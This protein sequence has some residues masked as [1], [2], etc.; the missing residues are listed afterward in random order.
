PA[1]YLGRYFKSSLLTVL[2]VSEVELGQLYSLYGAVAM[3]CYLLGGPIA[4]RVAPRKLIAGSLLATAAGGLWLASVPG[5]NALR[6]L[7]AFWGASTILAFWAPL[8]RATRELG[9]DDAQGRAFGLLDGG[10]G[11]AAALVAVA[12][13][14]GVAVL[15]G[16]DALDNATSELAAVR[17]LALFYAGCCVT[18]AVAVW[19]CLPDFATTSDAHPL[20]DTDMPNADMADGK[21]PDAAWRRVLA[22]ARLPAIWL[23]ALVVISAYTAFKAIDYYGLFCED[24]YGL[25]EAESARVVTWLSFL[26]VGAALAAGWIADRWLRASGTILSGFLML[27]VGYGV[28]LVLPAGRGTLPA[29]VAMLAVS[30]VA[31]FGLR[32]VYF[33]LFEECDLPDG[34]TGTAVGLVSFVGFTPEVFMPL[35]SSWLVQSARD[36][37]DV[38]TGYRQLFGL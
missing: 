36:A 2:G 25:G 23:Q 3:A 22:V 31:F 24:A 8:I 15:L 32:G 29:G 27:M 30:C 19:L 9:G 38:L 33:A 18:A 7:F 20:A 14:Q 12:S 10:R 34:L 16:A 37:G 13:V 21:V 17:S 28:L 11:L 1:F 6:L 4:D 35:V 26:R 5:L